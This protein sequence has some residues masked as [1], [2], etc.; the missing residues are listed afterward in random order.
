MSKSFIAIDL[1]DFHDGSKVWQKGKVDT[2]R[3]KVIGARNLAKAKLAAHYIEPG[4]AWYVFPLETM[5]SM[6]YAEV[7]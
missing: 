6:V 5:R 3:V 7:K 4:N 2:V 1:N